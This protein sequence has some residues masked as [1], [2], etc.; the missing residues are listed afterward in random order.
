MTDIPVPALLAMIVL[1]VW[2]AGRIYAAKMHRRAFAGRLP[3]EFDLTRGLVRAFIGGVALAAD[4]AILLVML[5]MLWLIKWLFG[6]DGPLIFDRISPKAI[7]S[8]AMLLQFAAFTFF[9]ALDTYRVQNEEISDRTG[10]SVDGGVVVRPWPLLARI[11]RRFPA[12]LAVYASTAA[13]AVVI[14]FIAAKTQ[15]IPG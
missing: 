14:I 11:A 10:A 9:S 1:L 2:P 15:G 13:F 8:F 7:L 5:T 3:L 12:E 4:F 6:A